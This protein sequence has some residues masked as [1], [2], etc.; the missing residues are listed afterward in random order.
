MSN[1][2]REL[3][4]TTS[5]CPSCLERVPGTYELRGESVHLTRSCPD[6]GTT[7]RRVW[8]SL[9]HWEWAGEFGPE[10]GGDADPDGALTVDNDHA[11]LAVVE[12]TEDCNL[13][14]SFCF[15]SSGPGGDHRPFEEVVEL[16]DT[17]RDTGGPR[18]VQ[19]SGGEP[20]VRDDL[21]EL[22]EKAQSMG[23]E[24]VQVNTNGLR[25]ATEDGHAETLAEAGVTAVYLQFDGLEPET[26][27]QV[28]EVDIAEQK[29]EAIAACRGADLPVVLVPTVVP[30]VNDHEMGDIV[31]FAL[32][33]LDVVESVNFQPVAQFGRYD[34]HGGRF[35]LDQA[36]AALADQLAG[37][38]RRD[39]LPI[40]CCSS[41]CQ[42]A[43]ALKPD[44]EGGATPLTQF[45]DDE[46]FAS[47]SGM[48]DESDWM[49]LLANT[50][51][52][53]ERACSAAGCCGPDLPEGAADLLGEV[54]PVSLTGFM[55]AAA[56]DVERL[57]NCCISVPTPDG[58]LVPFCAYNMTTDDGEYAL[59]NR[60]DWGGRPSVDA[61]TDAALDVDGVAVA[62]DAIPDGEY[63]TAGDG[64]D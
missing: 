21:P 52:G 23:F 10:V 32:D 60:N 51:A 2:P 36:A 25:L 50:T 33:N 45:V 43:T 31:R 17:I 55:D 15:A 63:P 53:Q 20:T 9:D 35:S 18:P 5:M 56:A 24:H 3:A 26:Y 41:Y 54:L 59:R 19:F 1:E 7:S 11:C 64:D 49:E 8:G 12:V 37:I 13:S 42:M 40:P 58:E 28:R 27:E 6:H 29:H 48:V 61:G 30:D 39:L 16:L 14:C 57:D 62:D 46:M 4:T 44:G 47:L 22:V 34:D 38:D